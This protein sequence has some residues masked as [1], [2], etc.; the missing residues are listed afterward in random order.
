MKKF[1]IACC[2]ALLAIPSVQAQDEI[3]LKGKQLFGDITARQIGPALMS[4]RIIDLEGH[5]T[6]N[7]IIYVGTAGGGVWKSSDGGASYSPIFDEYAN[8]IGVVAVDPS[9]PDNVVW[10]GTGEIWNRRDLDP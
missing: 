2:A 9:K 6:N 7:K 3:A 4:G 10:V 8:S 1:L 5:P